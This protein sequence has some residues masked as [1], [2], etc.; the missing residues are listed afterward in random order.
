MYVYVKGTGCCICYFRLKVAHERFRE[1]SRHIEDPCFHTQCPNNVR[2][3][4]HRYRCT[5]LLSENSNASH[6]LFPRSN[7]HADSVPHLK[8]LNI[9]K[10]KKANIQLQAPVN[11]NSG[12]KTKSNFS[13]FCFLFTNTYNSDVKWQQCV[14]FC[15][16]V[17]KM[18]LL[19]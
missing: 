11:T 5:T 19:H 17:L 18:Q 2:V 6:W 15:S 12:R 1:L 3:Q 9:I 8:E 7:K 13:H 4:M 16:E 10:H 14:M